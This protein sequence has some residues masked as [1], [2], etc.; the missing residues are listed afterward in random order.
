MSRLEKVFVR[1][2]KVHMKSQCT[3]IHF[4]MRN[5]GVV[6]SVFFFFFCV[7]LKAYKCNKKIIFMSF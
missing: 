5:V 3:C 6:F 7:Y 2:K 1:E 4:M